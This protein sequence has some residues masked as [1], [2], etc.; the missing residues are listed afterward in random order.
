METELKVDENT[1]RPLG[2]SKDEARNKKSKNSSE[3]QERLEAFKK[4]IKLGSPISTVI[5]ISSLDKISDLDDMVTVFE[6]LVDVA[7]SLSKTGDP[8]T[9]QTA[10]L[11]VAEFMAQNEKRLCTTNLEILP[12]LRKTVK[13]FEELVK[14]LKSKIDYRVISIFMDND[15]GG[16]KVTQTGTMGSLFRRIKGKIF[17]CETMTWEERNTILDHMLIA[18]ND[19]RRAFLT[20]GRPAV[21][22]YKDMSDEELRAWSTFA[23]E[24]LR[25]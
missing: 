10:I 3:Y 9:I 13:R 2:S 8:T 14:K 4:T 20:E 23:N 16:A 22:G 17:R 25:E 12:K 19:K 5:S 6:G 15:L 7:E 21:R 18:V 1:K 11:D 24:I